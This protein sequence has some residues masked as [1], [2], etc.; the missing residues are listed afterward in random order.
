MNSTIRT[1]NQT[2]RQPITH[3]SNN[4]HRHYDTSKQIVNSRESGT[5]LMN[6]ATSGTLEKLVKK[7]SYTVLILVLTIVAVAIISCGVV[8]AICR[9]RRQG[10]FKRKEPETGSQMR[11]MHDPNYHDF[12]IAFH[13]ASSM[14]NSNT[15]YNTNNDGRNVLSGQ[16]SDNMQSGTA[17]NNEYSVVVRDKKSSL[18]ANDDNLDQKEENSSDIMDNEYDRLNQIRIPNNNY[19]SK[20]IYDSSSGL[21]DECDP[22]YNISSQIFG[23]NKD[24]NTV[25]DHA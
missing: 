14:S 13:N 12:G 2:T 4:Q 11:E 15:A 24:D 6:I 18:R 1:E 16:T 5:T 25:Y 3:T 8:L 21:R 20:N 10:P 23:R 19:N 9:V 7:P 17:S 22:T